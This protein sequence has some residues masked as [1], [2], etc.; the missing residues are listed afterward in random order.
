M[1]DVKNGTYTVLDKDS[2]K[3]VT[4]NLLTGELVHEALPVALRC[5]VPYSVALSQAL[6]TLVREGMSINK[7]SMLEGMPTVSLMH[8]WCVMYPDFAENLKQARKDRAHTFHD[9]IIDVTDEV[10][11]NRTNIGKEELGAV[12]SVIENYKWLA[13][14]GNP[15]EYSS[16]TKITGDRENPLTFTVV[17]TGIRRTRPDVEVTC[18]RIE[19]GNDGV[20]ASE[21]SDDTA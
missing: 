3:L 2:G 7:I 9:R 10:Y 8:R 21:T 18:E 17:D 11:L 12:K 4:V 19:D 6:Y 5:K 13:E 20:C 15:E 14:R 1:E 16:R